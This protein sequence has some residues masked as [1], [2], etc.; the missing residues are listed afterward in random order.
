MNNPVRPRLVEVCRG[1]G[2]V[3]VFAILLVGAPIGLHAVA[4]SPVP[5][6]LPSSAQITTILLRPDTDQRLFLTAMRLLGW[7][8]WTVFAIATCTETISYLAG[9]SAPFLPRPVRPLQMLARNLLATATLVLST[10][11][12][13]TH[14]SAS[15]H[16]TTPSPIP[17]P[18]T[19]APSSSGADTT[20]T[21]DGEWAPLLSDKPTD[22]QA[23]NPTAWR[24]RVVERGDTLWA[25]A[26][27]AYGSGSLY[28]TIYKASKHLDQPDGVPALSNPAD[29]HPGQR[30]RLPPINK[31]TPWSAPSRPSPPSRTEQPSPDADTRADH[32]RRP[33]GRPPTPNAARPSPIPSPIVAPPPTG[34][35]TANQPSP[36]NRTLDEEHPS[37][38]VTLPSG[39]Y[40]GL[41]LAA[42]LSIAVAATRLHR[43]HQHRPGTT[44]TEDPPPREPTPPAPVAQVRKAHLD[45]TRVDQDASIPSDAE[46][47]A[48]DRITPAPES[49][50]LGTR[51]QHP[52]SLPLPGLH[53][54]LSGDTAL[55]AARAIITELLAKA[56]RDRVELLIPQPD[57]QA[58]YPGS[59][60]AAA[61]PGLTTMPNLSAALTQLEA[62]VL[63]R[64]RLL[65]TADQPDLPA[66]RATDPAEPLP[67]LL[68]V[69][70]TPDHKNAAALHT[71]T[72][73]ARRYGIGA[74]TLGLC[75]TATNAHLTDNTTITNADG[76]HA[77]TL[78]GA[79]LFHLTADDATAMLHTLHTATG[80]P[81][82]NNVSTSTDNGASSQTTPTTIQ[83]PAALAPPPHPAD[84]DHPRPARLQVLG[85]IRLHTANG[86]ITTGIRRSARD[87]LTYL[88]LHPD[89]ITRD[90]AI[91]A[92]WPDHSPDTATTA[93]NTAVA[94]IRKVLRT[95]TG[96]REPM[97]VIHIAGRYRL[98]SHLI[99]IDLWQLTRAL[100]HG[101]HATND[102]ERTAALKPIT[103]LYTADFATDLTYHW[104]EAHREYLRRAAIDALTQHARHLQHDHP[105]QALAVLEQAITHDPYAEHLYR[106]V[107]Q[108]QT[109]LGHP[110]AAHRTYQLLTTRLTDLNTEPNDQTHQLL[111]N[112]QDH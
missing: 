40:I 76:P 22:Q 49:I 58:I 25:I 83:E 57:L 97:F 1:L 63:R 37:S 111:T 30:I 29:L 112:L 78:L 36:T 95:H 90:Q 12:L 79:R 85:Q 19:P 33:P 87:L 54:S 77:S 86:L 8:A 66:L 100:T 89:G 65:E 27:R 81:P 80:A 105:E 26:H 39:S 4:G 7:A 6:T 71:I 72:Q 53:L 92:L 21:D 56:S 62:E 103:N 16:T 3:L 46:L 38:A 20:T 2:A 110:D 5:D 68:L 43:R 102:T 98:D 52:V 74:L 61:L 9:R 93:F 106:D 73:L 60:L 18:P 64:A 23:P 42:A 44:T 101:R 31:T 108:L 94:N 15:T 50:T 28:P 107:M 82:T 10:A 104:A 59:E 51:N 67:T 24:T 47:V 109:R 32:T 55:G 17:E 45:Q 75:P 14:A 70:S 11:T 88:A 35:P 48:H 69:A 84:E 13:T 91:G 34:Q 41:G 96:L 99:N